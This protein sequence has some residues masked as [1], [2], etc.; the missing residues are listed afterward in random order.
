MPTPEDLSALKELTAKAATLNRGVEQLINKKRDYQQQIADVET[1]IKANR[2][3]LT[4]RMGG[5]EEDDL[6]PSENVLQYDN[7]GLSFNDLQKKRDLLKERIEKNINPSI[8]KQQDKVRAVQAQESAELKRI[9]ASLPLE[10]QL[11]ITVLNEVGEA[12][13]IVAYVEK[14]FT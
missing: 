10:V 7:T 11:L 4:G 9:I 5:L 14:S 3:D 12:E 6:D 2:A 1:A 13:K 8:D